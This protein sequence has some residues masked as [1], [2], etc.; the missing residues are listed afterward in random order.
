MLFE[1]KKD[2]NPDLPK[3]NKSILSSGQV[4]NIDFEN[5]KIFS[6]DNKIDNEI[7]IKKHKNAI[8]KNSNFNITNNNNRKTDIIK[9]NPINGVISNQ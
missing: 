1:N 4:V 3:V 9:H 8:N 5:L 2:I 6:F 7:K